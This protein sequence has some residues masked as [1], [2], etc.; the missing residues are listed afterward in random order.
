MES[1]F[2]WV[3]KEGVVAEESDSIFLMLNFMRMQFT[4]EELKLSPLLEEYTM[5][6]KSQPTQD[7]NN[8]F[9]FVILPHLLML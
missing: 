2:Q 9:T 5:L 3:T 6:V 1:A 8:Q 4:E 7:S